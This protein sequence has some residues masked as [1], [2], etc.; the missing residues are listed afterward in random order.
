MPKEKLVHFTLLSHLKLSFQECKKKKKRRT[1]FHT[2][3]SILFIKLI[4]KVI[5][6][7]SKCLKNWSTGCPF[8]L[9]WSLLFIWFNSRSIWKLSRKEIL[10]KIPLLMVRTSKAKAG[11]IDISSHIVHS[12]EKLL[13]QT[14]HSHAQGQ[15]ELNTPEMRS[16]ICSAFLLCPTLPISWLGH[17]TG[18]WKRIQS[19]NQGIMFSPHKDFIREE[20]RRSWFILSCFLP[21]KQGERLPIN[22]V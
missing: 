2:K 21:A 7:D 9:F 6:I 17:E 3:F 11:I 20:V 8:T 18:S 10:N 22:D 1:S 14:G 13:W 4:L 12:G 15:A 16:A 5:K 19:L